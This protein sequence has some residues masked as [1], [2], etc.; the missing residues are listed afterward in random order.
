MPSA[1]PED[2]ARRLNEIIFDCFE[3]PGLLLETL[4]D[5]IGSTFDGHK[6]AV[7]GKPL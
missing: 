2:I 7:C 6:G 4:N 1:I 3:T 5:V